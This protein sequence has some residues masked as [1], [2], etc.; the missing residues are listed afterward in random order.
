MTAVSFAFQN[1]RDAAWDDP[2][3]KDQRGQILT[4][5]ASALWQDQQ[6]MREDMIRCARMYD[7]LPVIGLSPRL[8]SVRQSYQG[9]RR[10]VP[11][12]CVKA[13]IDTYVSLV[14]ED[15]PKLTWQTTGLDWS[16]QRRAKYSEQFV[17]GVFYDQ[18]LYS[19]AP[20]C[21]RDSAL[22]PFGCV[23]V[24]PDERDPEHP[25]VRIER[26][27][28]WEVLVDPDEAM[29]AAP[30]RLYQVKFCEKRALIAEHPDREAEIMAAGLDAFGDVGAGLDS[31]SAED[32]CA[33][34]EGWALPYFDQPGRWTQAVGDAVL[35]DRPYTRY[36]FPHKLLYKQRPVQGIWATSLAHD[37]GPIQAQIAKM[38]YLIEKSILSSV[39]HVL[40]EAS[41]NVNTNLLDNV[42]A[43]VIKYTGTPPQFVVGRP[44]DSSVTN[45]LQ[46]MW[47]KAF[48]MT[49]VSQMAAGGEVPKNFSSGKAQLVYAD[50]VS[51]RFT[52]AYREYQSW[53]RS[54]AEEVV[55]V[56]S[57]IADR[58]P[59][60][61]IKATTHGFTGLIKWADAALNDDE[62]SLQLL[63]TN[64]LADDPSARLAEVQSLTQAGMISPEDGRR[65]LDMPD[66]ENLYSLQDSAYN[67]VMSTVEAI[68]ERESYIP[69]DSY[70][71]LDELHQA[72][73]QMRMC[74]WKARI[75]KNTPVGAVEM[76]QRWMDQCAGEIEKQT[77]AQQGPGPQGPAPGEGGPV[78]GPPGQEP[79]PPQEPN[80]LG[81]VANMPLQPGGGGPPPGAP[82]Q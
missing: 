58:H 79:P 32:W 50:T 15:M 10:R 54:V 17:D 76:M 41:S 13:V 82:I 64:K 11:L 23:K 56:A 57:D 52:P 29:Y 71:G 9:M 3:N 34:V 19:T 63:P 70:F 45:H 60:F 77:A 80:P 47:A 62:Y 36:A 51:K 65:L 24:S 40:V 26:I 44:L 6:P 18:N 39:G 8:Y 73:S 21:V 27:F 37:L 72:L 25:R 75:Q 43:S 68:M 53:F 81:P 69:P 49:G 33:V 4:S 78:E 74:Y 16:L 42:V 1:T 46:M 38:L 31:I 61:A 28:P 30:S 67:L 55:Y 20:Q 35:D 48:E 14:T 2:R 7:N 66:L 12:N 59:D 22:F 5:M